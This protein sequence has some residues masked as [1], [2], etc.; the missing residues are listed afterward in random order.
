MIR[1]PLAALASLVL[2]VLGVVFLLPDCAY[3]CTCAIVGSQEERAKRAISRS[4]AVFSGEVVGFEKLEK[5]PSPTTMTEPTM[6]P[7]PFARDA[8]AKLRV[9]EV[10]KGPKQ[11]TVRLTTVTPFLAG[12]SCAHHFEEGREYL[13]YA[14]R[15]QD[16]LRVDDCSETKLLSNAGADLALLGNSGEKPKGDVGKVLSNTSGGFSGPALA[17]LAGLALAASVLLVVRLVRTG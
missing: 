8:I 3:A 4:D 1:R 10:W 6:F 16:S 7:T 15:R 2:T 14:N 5:P 12:G 13:V 17:G 11:R 9:A